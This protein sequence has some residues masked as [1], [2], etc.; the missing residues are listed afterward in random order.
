MRVSACS[1]HSCTCSEM[2]LQ[3]GA[4][5]D[6]WTRIDAPHHIWFNRVMGTSYNYTHSLLFRQSQMHPAV[7]SSVL[8]QLYHGNHHPGLSPGGHPDLPCN[9]VCPRKAVQLEDQ[10]SVGNHGPDRA[11]HLHAG[12]GDQ[13]GGGGPRAMEVPISSLPS[14]R[15]SFMLSCCYSAATTTALIPCAS[16]CP[17]PKTPKP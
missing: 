1:L 15:S 7:E 4:K 14:L 12:G 8:L 16:L 5:T 3:S 9:G 6:G 10:Q 17:N 11:V 13:S 2:H